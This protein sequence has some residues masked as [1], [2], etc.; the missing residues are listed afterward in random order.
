MNKLICQKCGE[1]YENMPDCPNC[2]SI[3]LFEQLK[4]IFRSV[5]LTAL[6]LFI[7]FLIVPMMKGANSSGYYEM[8]VEVGESSFSYQGIVLINIL[9]IATAIVSFS[10][11]IFFK[12]KLSSK[13]AD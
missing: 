1:E 11:F 7:A 5:G 10:L 3:K 12:L 2:K 13:K 9:L 6:I 8:P 4:L